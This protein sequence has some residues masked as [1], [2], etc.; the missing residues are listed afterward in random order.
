MGKEQKFSSRL[1]I[2]FVC[3]QPSVPRFLTKLELA[4]FSSLYQLSILQFSQHDQQITLFLIQF[5]IKTLVSNHLGLK[6]NLYTHFFVYSLRQYKTITQIFS[7]KSYVDSG[8]SGPVT[9]SKGGRFNSH[10]GSDVIFSFPKNKSYLSRGIIRW[11]QKTSEE[12]A[13]GVRSH[14]LW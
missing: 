6:T 7:S 8:T 1:T 13:V 2:G 9:P 4:S 14:D 5:S 3:E 11:S 12:Y 10:Q